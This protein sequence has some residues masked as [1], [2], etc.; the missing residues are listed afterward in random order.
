M[1]LKQEMEYQ[2]HD[3]RVNCVIIQKNMTSNR[4]NPRQVHIRPT[5]VGQAE[6]YCVQTPA[7][8]TIII[9]IG[10]TM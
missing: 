1:I 2:T 4:G 9:Y 6:N 8:S 3:E 10:I 5:R 7:K